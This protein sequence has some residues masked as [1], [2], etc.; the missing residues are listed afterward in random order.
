MFTKE[1]WTGDFTCCIMG[2]PDFQKALDLAQAETVI[3]EIDEETYDYFLCVMPPRK[4]PNGFQ[5]G[6]CVTFGK[7]HTFE[8]RN[9]KYYYRGIK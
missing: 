5:C 1:Q 9:G 4:Y 2:E 6:E 8:N 3:K 7:Y